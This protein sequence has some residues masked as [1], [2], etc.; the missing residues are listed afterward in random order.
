L[1]RAKKDLK[2]T[3]DRYLK[4]GLSQREALSKAVEDVKGRH[5]E[6]AFT[7]ALGEFLKEILSSY[8]PENLTE[9]EPLTAFIEALIEEFQ[10]LKPQLRALIDRL[11]GG[12]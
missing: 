11:K 1:E 4:E 9:A 5:S 3:Y 7:G 8:K 10:I 6:E 12:R 2:E